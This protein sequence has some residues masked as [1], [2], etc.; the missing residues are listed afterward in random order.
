MINHEL[1][2]GRVAFLLANSWAAN[3]GAE[4]ILYSRYQ[5]PK[6]ENTNGK[7]LALGAS[8]FAQAIASQMQNPLAYVP[9]RKRKHPIEKAIHS[10]LLRCMV[11]SRISYLSKMSLQLLVT[12]P[13]LPK[14]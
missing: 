8:L 2:L 13:L 11:D 1:T 4:D 12:K 3:R 9:Q 14:T 6:P 10:T 7:T 5:V